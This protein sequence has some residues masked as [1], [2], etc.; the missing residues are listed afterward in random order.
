MQR[1]ELIRE[2]SGLMFLRAMLSEPCRSESYR[3]VVD[4]RLHKSENGPMEYER[5]EPH[6]IQNVLQAICEAQKYIEQ[7]S[8]LTIE[9]FKKIHK[10][11]RDDITVLR[12]VPSGEF[13]T[14]DNH[15]FPISQI[16]VKGLEELCRF[17]K[18]YPTIH[19]S[20]MCSSLE[21]K[22]ESV[23]I[24]GMLSRQR[25]QKPN[26]DQVRF[27]YMV[28]L[29]KT[30]CEELAASIIEQCR[31][32]LA[33]ADGDD[34]AIINAIVECIYE[35]EL[36]HPFKDVNLRTNIVIADILLMQH[37]F[38]PVTYW[39]PNYLDG[40]S[41][42]EFFDII[43][44]GMLT[45]LKIIRNPQAKYFDFKSSDM[46]KED[47]EQ[48]QAIVTSVCQ[49]NNFL[50]SGDVVTEE[51]LVSTQLRITA[52]TSSMQ[53]QWIVNCN[54]F[55]S[56]ISTV[57]QIYCELLSAE[58]MET[59]AYFDNDR[60]YYRDNGNIANRYPPYSYNN[61]SDSEKNTQ[62]STTAPQD[63]DAVLQ[64]TCLL[65]RECI[66]ELLTKCHDEDELL[67]EISALGDPRIDI[68]NGVT[69]LSIVRE[70]GTPQAIIEQW[71]QRWSATPGLEKNLVKKGECRN[72]NY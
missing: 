71:E 22:L 48:Y 10:I 29:T 52:L 47:Q 28:N 7:K 30:I 4:G 68:G 15:G 49:N 69:L 43:K 12:E 3:I 55:N 57:F 50:N 23:N 58:S 5:R 72:N 19:T 65:Y 33:K 35:L 56:Q 40:C 54:H 34:N 14:K 26:Q 31:T 21:Q 62:Q 45:T 9:F 46:T 36:L 11:C 66:S 27:L 1:E 63:E 20:F 25:L 6:S 37:G 2:K 16:S 60:Y 59:T 38:P 18:K 51:D 42:N 41:K 67:K 13:I 8:V 61:S 17:S 44:E 53:P 32:A 24:Y 70:Y 64:E 39:D